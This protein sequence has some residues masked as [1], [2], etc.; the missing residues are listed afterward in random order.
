MP[1][2]DVGHVSVLVLGAG[3]LVFVGVSHLGRVMCVELIMAVPVLMDNRHV[4]V[5]MGMLLIGQ[6]KRACNHQSCGDKKRPGNGIVKYKDGK[7][8]ACQGSCPVQ[9]LVREAPRPRME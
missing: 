2:M 4:D 3:M 6:Q 8:H 9:A 1:V 7:D 5:E